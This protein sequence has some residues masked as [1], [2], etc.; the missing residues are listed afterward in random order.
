MFDSTLF[1]NSKLIMFSDLKV[2]FL[3][4][5][6]ISIEPNTYPNLP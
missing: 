4:K 2:S 5:K 3:R 1:N 6:F